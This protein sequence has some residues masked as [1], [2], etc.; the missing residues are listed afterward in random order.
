MLVRLAVRIFI[1]QIEQARQLRASMSLPM[2]LPDLGV[3]IVCPRG[4]YEASCYQRVPALHPE[5]FPVNPCG[6]SY[7]R[8]QQERSLC[9]FRPDVGMPDTFGLSRESGARS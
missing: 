4:W 3:P 5:D 8:R 9:S 7:D 6:G 1:S 2:A